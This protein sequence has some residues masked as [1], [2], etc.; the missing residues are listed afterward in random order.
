VEHLLTEE[1]IFKQFKLISKKGQLKKLF[2][3][4]PYA[5]HQ[6]TLLSEVLGKDISER[7]V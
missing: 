3:L 4:L 5:A 7:A 2:S 1:K 6:D